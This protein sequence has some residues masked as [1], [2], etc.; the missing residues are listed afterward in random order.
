MSHARLGPGP[1][2]AG[3]PEAYAPFA[4]GERGRSKL[5]RYQ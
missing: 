5:G 3:F 2:P 1:D 4:V